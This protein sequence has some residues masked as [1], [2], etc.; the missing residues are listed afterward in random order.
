[1][2]TAPVQ[3]EPRRDL[4]FYAMVPRL[5][6]TGYKTL[7]P[8][9]KWLYVCLKDLCGDNGTCYRT[10]KT[11]CTETSL[12][13]GAL[14]TMIRRLHLIGLIHATKR[15]RSDDAGHEVWHISIVD[16]WGANA[17]HRSRREQGDPPPDDSGPHRSRG[18]PSGE[19]GGENHSPGEQSV[20][21]VND[22]APN[23]SPREADRSR[24]GAKEETSE[25]E[26]NLKKNT[27]E[28]WVRAPG[29][30]G[31]SSSFSFQK[32]RK[33]DSSSPP[34]CIEGI[35]NIA[36]YSLPLLPTHVSR[37]QRRKNDDEWYQAA[38][39]LYEHTLFA[40]L[41]NDD[42]RI[43]YL[44][45]I[46]SFV[47]HP[48]SPCWW[49]TRFAVKNGADKLRLW[50]VANSLRSICAD[51]EAHRW[52]GPPPVPRPNDEP[53]AWCE[54]LPAQPPDRLETRV[55]GRLPETERDDDDPE[56]T[57]TPEVEITPQARDEN[58][59]DLAL[60]DPEPA[61]MPLAAAEVLRQQIGRERPAFCAQVRRS[62]GGG[63][64]IEVA[65]SPQQSY[66]L[67]AEEAWDALLA[68]LKS[69][70]VPL[71][72][73]LAARRRAEQQREAV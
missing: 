2:V 34:W 4:G 69:A 65:T 61:G 56:P 23:R 42:A 60:D 49:V 15:R 6:R 1:M 58:E 7:S 25:E 36:A 55:A 39:C 11:L 44:V 27:E 45:R 18:E 13:T 28:D 31:V 47:T 48:L 40:A 32:E 14:S 41:P 43:E 51:M 71:R 26:Q 59:D 64:V 73:R 19:E 68:Q 24:F 70:Y 50:H 67:Y 53:T 37:E 30:A 10:L 3:S 17:Q 63:F 54:S 16:I 66:L 72:E 33:D 8:A 35:F 12:S 57:V 22:E 20:H 38:K 21:D 62:R 9:T 52:F 46:F 29:G 5:V